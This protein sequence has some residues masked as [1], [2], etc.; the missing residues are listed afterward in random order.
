VAPAGPRSRKC[1][2]AQRSAPPQ[3]PAAP[4]G[5]LIM[6]VQG[7]RLRGAL[8]I[9]IVAEMHLDA[10][11]R[12]RLGVHLRH[13]RAADTFF[14]NFCSAISLPFGCRRRHRGW[15][16]AGRTAAGHEPCVTCDAIAG[17]KPVQLLSG[18]AAKSNSAAHDKDKQ[19]WVGAAVRLGA[20]RR[21]TTSFR[22]IHLELIPTCRAAR[23]IGAALRSLAPAGHPAI[24]TLLAA[25]ALSEY[26]P[27]HS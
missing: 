16:R 4:L 17:T 20:L 15:S 24:A 9:S 27:E 1:P 19:G 6:Q 3:G 13:P 14:S 11:N 5:G 25:I 7:N 18:R 8:T 22:A 12:S 2:G 21:T 10:P 23:F 26:S